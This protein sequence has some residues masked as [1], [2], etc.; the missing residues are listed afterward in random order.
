MK[1]IKVIIVLILITS[2]EVFCQQ[3]SDKVVLSTGF[4]Y[5]DPERTG[6]KGNLF[7]SKIT[8][9]TNT[10][11]Y[12]GFSFES[13]L[14]FNR[15]KELDS[16]EDIRFYETMYLYNLIVENHILQS[17]NGKHNLVF[18]TGIIYEQIKS[19]EPRINTTTD[20]NGEIIRYLDF[21]VKDSKQNNAGT[22][23]EL[24]YYWQTKRLGL[25]ARV[26]GNFL[27]DI[28]YSGL[29]VTPT[30]SVKL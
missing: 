18:G 29:I 20:S 25:G 8:V 28:G 21:D 24:G 17:S 13:S 27:L 4:G 5:F 3:V 6:E 30:L 19:S 26:K 9:K 15:Y 2:S 23:I 1:Y 22:F 14:L 7:F 12:V 11:L 16:F 10:D